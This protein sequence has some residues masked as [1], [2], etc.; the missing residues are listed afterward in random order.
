MHMLVLS[1]K[2]GE[3]IVIS[4][5]TITITVLD[6]VHGKVRLGFEAPPEIPIFRSELLRDPP[7]QAIGKTPS[8]S[9]RSR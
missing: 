6:I 3:K 8:T 4:N 5:T 2:R 9:S 1:R 7:P